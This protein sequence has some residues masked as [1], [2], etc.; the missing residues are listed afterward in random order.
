MASSM[1]STAICRFNADGREWISV[2][3]YY[4][5]CKFADPEHRERIRKVAPGR[6]LGPR[7]S[8]STHAR[9][10]ST[11]GQSRDYALDD[12]FHGLE[13]MYVATRAKFEQNVELRR[14]LVE[15]Q[16]MIP[17]AVHGNQDWM[18]WNAQILERIREELRTE[19]MRDEAR[20]AQLRHEFAECIDFEEARVAARLRSL[21]TVP[22]LPSAWKLSS[23]PSSARTLST[24]ATPRPDEIVAPDAV[25]GPDDY[26]EVGAPEVASKEEGQLEPSK[27][28]RP[29]E[30]SAA[31]ADGI[32]GSLIFAILLL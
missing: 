30:T 24:R 4:Q 12:S 18:C 3:Q 26:R 7:I 31:A 25:D 14:E 16:G 6:N 32:I 20:L 22:R 27:T 5:A 11:L 15:S 28:A 2:E 13:T 21:D 10:V 9:E 1:D 17:L 19:D 8:A 23:P 29:P